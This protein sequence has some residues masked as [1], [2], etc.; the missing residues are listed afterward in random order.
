MSG[1]RL[2]DIEA[3]QLEKRVMDGVREEAHAILAIEPD[4]PDR[5]LLL[6]LAW[7]GYSFEEITRIV[8]IER[9]HDAD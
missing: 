1:W 5:W 2:N 6:R 8:D 3:M 7:K 9:R 4:I